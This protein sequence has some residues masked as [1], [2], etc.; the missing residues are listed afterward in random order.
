MLYFTDRQDPFS[1]TR[2]FPIS[3]CAIN[4]CSRC[5]W[6]AIY[7]TLKA[8]TIYFSILFCKWPLFQVF[9]KILAYSTDSKNMGEYI[10]SRRYLQ[11]FIQYK[12]TIVTFF[13]SFSCEF[14]F[15][16]SG[17]SPSQPPFLPCQLV[18]H[19]QSEGIVLPVTFPL[20]SQK[21]IHHIQNFLVLPLI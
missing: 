17:L 4:G 1:W 6:L 5:H 14:Y 11:R 7:S 21:Q 10:S 3:I 13:L 15:S 18:K 2:Y 9:H 16:M 8:I 19:I 12:S 20:L